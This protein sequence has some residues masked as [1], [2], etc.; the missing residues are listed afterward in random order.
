MPAL[1][2]LLVRD[3]VASIHKIEEALQRQVLEGGEIDTILLELA[4]VPENVLN[5]YRAALFDLPPASRHQVMSVGPKTLAKVPREIAEQF[6]VVP[7]AY[8]NNRLQMAI[9]TPLPESKIRELSDRLGFEL[10][11]CVTTEVRVEAALAAH[12]GIE[13]T[14]RMR[15]LALQLETIDPGAL[16]TIAVSYEQKAM[17]F[18]EHFLDEFWSETLAEESAQEGGGQQRPKSTETAFATKGLDGS[19]PSRRVVWSAEEVP[20]GFQ[21]SETLRGIEPPRT[22]DSDE[23]ESSSFAEPKTL[24]GLSPRNLRTESDL[25]EGEFI[26]HKTLEGLA[27]VSTLRRTVGRARVVGVGEQTFSRTKA[28][29]ATETTD[30]SRVEVRN[31]KSIRSSR[32]YAPRGPLTP[33]VTR[34][35]LESTDDRDSIIDL[36]FSFARQYFDCAVLLAFREDCA[37]G[38]E[39]GGYQGSDDIRALSIPLKKGGVL[40]DLQHSLLPRVTDLTRRKEDREFL[41][42]FGRSGIRPIALLPICIRQRVVLLLYG[43]RAGEHFTLD[44]LSDVIT[45]LQPVGRAFERLIH[46]SKALTSR[47]RQNARPSEPSPQPEVFAGANA[48]PTLDVP[49]PTTVERSSGAV[50]Q[51]PA[52]Q[53]VE[54]AAEP[55]SRPRSPEPRPKAFSGTKT[56]AGVRGGLFQG[57]PTEARYRS[58]K[59]LSGATPGSSLE[60]ESSALHRNGL[61]ESTDLSG[62]RSPQAPE[63]SFHRDTKTM[64][65]LTAGQSWGTAEPTTRHQTIPVLK[66]GANSS[67]PGLSDEMARDASLS[68]A[69]E[70]GPERDRQADKD[71]SA[72]EPHPSRDSSRIA[73]SE[74]I[75]PEVGAKSTSRDGVVAVLS[76][77]TFRGEAEQRSDRREQA[78][79]E[80]PSYRVA[81]EGIVEDK[82]EAKIAA[83]KGDGLQNPIADSSIDTSE[84]A[85]GRFER[86][87][88][89]LEQK[90]DTRKDKPGEPA[91]VRTGVISEMVRWSDPPKQSPTQSNITDERQP[92][93]PLE[94]RPSEP[95]IVVDLSLQTEELL[96]KLYS[97]SPDEVGSTIAMILRAGDEMLVELER[98]FPGPLWLDR[99]Q[100]I[101]D[102]PAAKNVSAISRTLVA[103]GNKAVPCIR[104]LLLS[105]D[106]EK[107]FYALLLAADVR[108]ANLL[109]PL[110]QRLFDVDSQIRQLAVEVLRR[111]RN[112]IGFRDTLNSLHLIASSTDRPVDMRITAL[113]TIAGLRDTDAFGLLMNLLQYADD[114]VANMARRVLVVLTLQDFGLSIRKW[115]A[116][117]KR[118]R[119][120]DRIEWM[121]ESLT[122]SDEAIREAAGAELQKT[123]GEY[124]GY[125]PTLPKR[126]RERIQKKYRTWW[127]ERRAAR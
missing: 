43:D 1:T 126:D 13:I 48:K 107:R 47:L 102:L 2:S 29:S 93:P 94:A 85:I 11:F 36:F 124:Y 58:R 33:G 127:K 39:S 24:K 49:Q 23:I 10:E 89:T 50:D 37:V 97:S 35:L 116:W 31:R 45:L 125:H 88:P 77:E 61:S 22:S 40:D 25:A 87:R 26:E 42:A 105:N 54:E 55:K 12:Y 110:G 82:A 81:I 114:A 83:R 118:N 123:T 38:I 18:E 90:S 106:R 92:T 115:S 70:I 7:I 56:L 96:E 41:T 100:P 74:S 28:D 99:K 73:P 121:I 27:K 101:R 86:K 16:P 8:Q 5:V 108:H 75:E 104:S 3:Q 79:R 51:Q 4:A 15:L 84:N 78:S 9:A 30:R 66:G 69:S 14:G 98:R 109:E 53:K 117:I 76:D 103:L 119:D 111:Y 17:H 68:P 63:T 59:T 120:T 72:A 71:L 80:E 19:R 44:D 67:A 21:E 57:Q 52:R 64:P 91:A 65:G 46:V 20:G 122:H 113:Q 60:S 95:S 32:R 6:R 62:V 112:I 34:E